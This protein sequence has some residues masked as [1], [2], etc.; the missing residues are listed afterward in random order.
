MYPFVRVIKEIW[1][2]RRAPKLGLMDTHVTHHVCWPWDLDVF[3]ELNNGRTLTL[4]D[5]GRISMGERTVFG[6]TLKAQRW[7]IAV[8]GNT[9][10]YRRRV[11]AF[12]RL[13][14]RTRCIGWDA[15]FLYMEQS[16]WKGQECTSQQVIRSAVTSKAGIVAPSELLKAMGEVIESPSLPE[17]VVAWVAA[18]ALRPW[19]PER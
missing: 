1:L 16:M 15:R 5:L 8:A 2:G 4:F 19:P 7:G 9:V 12:D 17:W 10:R 14:I 11:R 6:A 3:L 18:E 13:T